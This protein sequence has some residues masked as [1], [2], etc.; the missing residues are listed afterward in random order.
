MI[1]NKLNIKRLLVKIYFKTYLNKNKKK[2]FK[3]ILITLKKISE[4]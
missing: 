1:V 3:Q 2:G 4:Q